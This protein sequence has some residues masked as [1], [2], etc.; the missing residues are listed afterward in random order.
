M[1]KITK[2]IINAIL[3][4]SQVAYFDGENNDNNALIPEIWA[5]ESLLQLTKLSIYPW[6]VYKEF[7]NAVA[8]KGDTVNAWLPKNFHLT[9]KGNGALETQDAK[10]TSV[11]VRLDQHLLVSF[12]IKDGEESKAMKDLISVYLVP[13]MRAIAEGLDQI[14][15][16]QVYQFI[17]NQTGTLN[18][19]LDS[20]SLAN[21]KAL[22]TNNRVPVT[23][24]Y[25]VLTSNSE[26]KLTSKD[27]F[28]SAEKVG[29]DGTALREGSLG[30]K[31]GAN[32]VTDIATPSI[33]GGAAGLSKNVNLTGGYKKGHTGAITVATGT[34]HGPQSVVSILGQVYTVASGTA[35]TVVLNE[36]LRQDVPDTTPVK[37][38]AEAAMGSTAGVTTNGTTAG[39]P[40]GYDQPV[41]ITG[42]RGQVGEAFRTAAGDIYTV[43]SITDSGA[44]LLDRPLVAAI[45]AT[46]A[47]GVFPDGDYNFAFHN[48]A[49]A[50]VTRPLAAPKTGTGALSAVVEDNGIGIRVVITYDGKEQGHRVTIDL[51]AGVKVLNNKLGAVLLG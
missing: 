29:D 22:M 4:Q 51:L 38:V 20:A 5:M 41:N 7:S 43:V 10:A 17:A 2:A 1:K 28:I 44:Y 6:L 45:A 37:Q 9:R 12:V 27:L 35:T 31:Y 19:D 16:A 14:L 42:L 24:R 39:Y 47:L 18:S 30:R 33:Y 46:A 36:P 26:A 32:N 8:N 23:D 34:A 11:P 3:A 40:A 48:Q 21:L 13:A 25:N 50:L 15:A 49:I